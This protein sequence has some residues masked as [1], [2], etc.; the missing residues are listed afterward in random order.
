MEGEKAFPVLQ[1]FGIFPEAAHHARRL[2]RRMAM[3][4]NCL[5]FMVPCD[6]LSL[7]INELE[8]M[9]WNDRIDPFS[10]G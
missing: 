8:E 1:S 5:I 10:N 9:V 4:S 3:S 7:Y 2:P 6:I